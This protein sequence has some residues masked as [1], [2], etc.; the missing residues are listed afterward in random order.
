MSLSAIII[1]D[2]NIHFLTYA[3]TLVKASCC[4]SLEESI[5]S[6]RAS[7]FGRGA[8]AEH[9]LVTNIVSRSP[10]EIRSVITLLLV[11]YLMT[12]PDTLLYIPRQ[13]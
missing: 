3:S 12:P 2:D 10:D 8:S 5:L 9:Y 13:T 4:D 6:S 11:A 7:I 1:N